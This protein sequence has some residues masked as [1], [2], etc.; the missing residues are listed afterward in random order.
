MRI[1]GS[2]AKKMQT[3]GKILESFAKDPTFNRKVLS[4]KDEGKKGLRLE[5]M[6]LPPDVT[7]TKPIG[8]TGAP[9]QKRKI[10]EPG[11]E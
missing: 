4:L 9:G 1:P 2:A 11:R 10:P 5:L 7:S 8:V 6:D 3:L